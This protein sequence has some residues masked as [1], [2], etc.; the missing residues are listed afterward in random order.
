MAS[1]FHSTLAKWIARTILPQLCT[2]VQ[3]PHSPVVFCGTVSPLTSC[4]LRYSITTPQLC[5]AVQYPHSPAVDCGTISPLPSCV[6]RYSILT[7]QLC[8]VVQY[9]NSPAV[10]CCTASPLIS[11]IDISIRNQYTVL[12]STIRRH[13][14][15]CNRN[16]FFQLKLLVFFCLFSFL[17]STN[18]NLW[19]GE[20]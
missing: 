8:A 4:L 9:P 18:L 7:P 15:E 5:T 13:L 19:W 16:A 14:C 10:C 2:A 3:Y 12:V 17:L 1:W 6:L 20:K 11:L